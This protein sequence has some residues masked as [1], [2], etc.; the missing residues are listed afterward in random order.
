[1]AN[2]YFTTYKQEN[3]KYIL[4]ELDKKENLSNDLRIKVYLSLAKISGNLNEEF[5]YYKK[6]VSLIT[7]ETDKSVL[8]QLYY[9][10]AG[11]YDEKDDIKTAAFYYKKCIEIK[12]NNNYLSRAMANLAELYEE[13]GYTDFAVKYYEKS[14]EIDK[15]IKNYNGLYSSAR[16][17]SEI[18]AP[19]DSA[20]SLEYLNQSY[21]Y[22]KQLNEPFYIADVSS[23]IGNYY[24]LRKDFDN[25]Y[26]YFL[27]AKTTAKTSMTKDNAERFDSK[28]D[29]IKKYISDEEFMKLE[30]KYGK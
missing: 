26:K 18:Y 12:D 10:F 7:D 23:E 27:Q 5:S 3:A 28:L 30:E 22:A 19:K 24:L 17:L 15:D 13:T 8:S 9:R 4:N 16:H 14:I 11:V 20:K 21:N 25:A 29:Y 6:S 1:M 2:I